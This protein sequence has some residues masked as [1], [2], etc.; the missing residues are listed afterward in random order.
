MLNLPAPSGLLV[1]QGGSPALED[2]ITA[3][4]VHGSDGLGELDGVLTA[5]GVPRYPTVRLPQVLPTAQDVEGVYSPLPGWDD[6]DQ[7]GAIDERGGRLEGIRSRYRSSVR[8]WRW[9]RSG[10]PER[11]PGG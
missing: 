8:W 5:G 11:V 6:A 1:G 2:P 7:P 9:G 3:V 10:C 4:Q